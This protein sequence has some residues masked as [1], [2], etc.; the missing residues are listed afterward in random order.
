[1]LAYIKGGKEWMPL[2][3]YGEQRFK[4]LRTFQYYPPHRQHHTSTGNPS[5]ISHY[6]PLLVHLERYENTLAT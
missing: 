4:V 3:E 5:M 2:L 1:L 6:K